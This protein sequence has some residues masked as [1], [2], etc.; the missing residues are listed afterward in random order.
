MPPP[1]PTYDPSGIEYYTIPDFHFSNGT[2]LHDVKVAYREYN[3]DAASSAGTVLIPTCYAGFINTT[4]TFTN[5]DGALSKYHVVVVAMLGNGESASSSNKSFFPGPGE[6]RYP[7][8]VRAQH[9]LVVNQFGI[10][11][12]HP[13][14]A[15]IG[16]SMGGQQ[17]YHWSVMFP[18]LTRRAVA[19]C[20]AARTSLHNYAFLEGPIAA[21]TNSIDYVAWRAMK[22]KSARGEAVGAHLKEV[23][24]KRGLRAFARA[25]AAWLTSPQWFRDRLFRTDSM[26][27]VEDWM[28]VREQGYMLWDAEDLLVLARM[29]Q[30]GDVG[31]VYKEK[32]DG[33]GEGRGEEQE[34][35]NTGDSQQQSRLGGAVPDDERFVKALQSITSRVL[36]MPCRTDQ[37]FPPED[38]E[39]EMKH[40]KNARLAVIESSWG[41]MAGGGAN[42]KDVEFMNEQIARFMEEE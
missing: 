40:L 18:T 32:G 12:Q 26:G 35:S 25:Y 19:I 13:L 29:W 21:L 20:S 5:N 41:H 17:A 16:F 37:Y 6:L 24:P 2:T 36:L 7:D 23:V 31:S 4:L 15:V 27:T 14:E 11:A 42:P 39:F 22:E 3:R 9:S 34:T 10:S 28:Q 8:V 33:N 30:M 38:S 1:A